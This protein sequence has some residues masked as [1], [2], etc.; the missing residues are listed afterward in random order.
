[1][2]TRIAGLASIARHPRALC[3]VVW[4]AFGPSAD[5]VTPQIALSLAGEHAL[6]LRADATLTA[7]GSNTFGQL[8][9]GTP[10]PRAQPVQVVPGA[11]PDG[12]H[13][14]AVASG[15]NHTLVLTNTGAVYGWGYNGLGQLGDGSARDASSA[16]R[17][18]LPPGVRIVSVSAGGTH[19]LA[20]GSEGEVL[21]W[22]NNEAGQ[23]GLGDND[24]RTSPAA[25]VVPAGVRFTQLSAGA[26]HSLALTADGRLYAWG[27]NTYGQLG[28]SGATPTNVPRPVALGAAPAGTT[29]VQVVAGVGYSLALSTAGELFAWGRNEYG[30][31]GDG[32]F[33][34]QSAP[35]PVVTSALPVGVVFRSVAAGAFHAIALGSDARAYAWGYNI[36]GQLGDGTRQPRN[37]PQAV[38]AGSPAFSAVAAGAAASMALGSDQ[39][40]YT[41]GAAEGGLLADSS[42]AVQAVPL[43][44]ADTAF[45]ALAAGRDHV[46]AM[47]PA[48]GLLAWGGNA[49]GQLGDGSHVQRSRAVGVAQGERSASAA[50]QQI[51]AG[52]AFSLARTADGLTYLWGRNDQGQLGRAAGEPQPVPATLGPLGAGSALRSALGAA[53]ALAV[54]SDGQLYA[55]GS[56]GDGQLGTSGSAPAAV[57]AGSLGARVPTVF[58]AGRTHSLAA[59]SDGQ[60]HAW[61]DNRAGQLGDATQVSRSVPVAINRGAIPASVDVMAL[62]AGDRFSLALANDGKVYAWGANELGQL[63]DGGGAS[64]VPR[65]VPLDSTRF[66]ALAAGHDHVLALS[67]A[68]EVWSWGGNGT[69]QLGDGGGA[70]RFSP[71]R[72]PGLS[73]ISA[74]TAGQGFSLALD[75]DGIAWGWGDNREGQL[76]VS[77]RASRSLPDLARD[78]SL[79]PLQGSAG[80]SVEL[81]PSRTVTSSAVRLQA[82]VVSGRAPPAGSVTFRIDGAVPSGCAAR[83]VLASGSAGIAECNLPLAPGSYTLAADFASADPLISGASAA[84][85]ALQVDPTPDAL[86]DPFAFAPR[87]DVLPG[88]EQV[89]ERVTVSGINVPVTVTVTGGDYSIG[90]SSAW[91]SAAQSLNPGDQVCVRHQAAREFATTVQTTL[92]IGSLAAA[93]RSTT[94]ADP[95]LAD[96]AGDFDGDGIPNAVERTIGRD[97]LVR[98]NDV[99]GDDRLFVMQSYR[100]V[101]NRESD[102]EGLAYWLGELTAGRQARAG[103]IASL[104]SAPEVTLR[105][106]VVRLYLAAFTRAPDPAGLAYWSASGA[107]LAA[108]GDAF[109]ASAEFVAR[110]GSLSDGDFVD[111]LY[112]NVLDRAP[113]AAGAAYWLDALT[114]RQISRG[115]LLAALS[116]SAEFRARSAPHVAVSRV[117]LALLRREPDAQGLAFWSARVAAGAPVT[118]LISGFLQAAEYLR[119]FP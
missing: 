119:R 76:G 26:D 72:V 116:E 45:A 30:Q 83:P 10:L 84:A 81:S 85:R 66:R 77:L 15:N 35:V 19:S 88:S 33:A 52:D 64:L 9:D 57:T 38:A 107:P 103:L 95:A 22:G 74:I 94:R 73:R 102:G 21:A 89:S 46:L 60:L 48:G 6:L 112:R 11:M 53:H 108:I 117:Y 32:S 98:D 91:T 44:L 18:L 59:T 17:V 105:D 54:A 7:W 80:S 55:W 65:A 101:L 118:E 111:R 13:A 1:M 113:D 69:G 109:A 50:V 78:A 70:S 28:S 61:G 106:P 23:L 75:A 56:N 90:C 34:R 79:Q 104:V 68:G 99:P 87:V 2:R 43:R 36:D 71:G 47:T 37:F 58:A 42:R 8:G 41:W 62:A 51:A 100:D 29:F 12:V 20:L 67:E 97:V 49:A 40:V 96:P 82:R 24:N 25:L 14:V 3:A 39:R 114:S 93:F 16:Q 4:L 110:Y 115:G 27:D 92:Q 63:G 31:L 5:A 86:P